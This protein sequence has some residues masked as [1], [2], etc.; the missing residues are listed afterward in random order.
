MDPIILS[1]VV[2]IVIIIIGL[3]VNFWQRKQFI[4]NYQEKPVFIIGTD[5]GFG[6]NL[7]LALDKKGVKVYAGCYTEDGL[8]S[9]KEESSDRMKCVKID[10]T[11]QKSLLAAKEFIE[12]DLATDKR[13]K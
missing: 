9:L 7:A 10:V 8:Q 12:A 5:T 11:D 13:S 6:R 2:I 1:L 4:H 3:C